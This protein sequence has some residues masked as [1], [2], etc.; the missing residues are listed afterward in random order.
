MGRLFFPSK[1]SDLFLESPWLH[2]V[3]WHVHCSVDRSPVFRQRRGNK[4]MILSWAR[5]ITNKKQTMSATVGNMPMTLTG[6]A[7]KTCCSQLY[8]LYTHNVTGSN[9]NFLFYKWSDDESPYVLLCLASIVENPYTLGQGYHEGHIPSFK[10]LQIEP[11]PRHLTVIM[12]NETKN[13]VEKLSHW[14]SVFNLCLFSWRKQ[15]GHGW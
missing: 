12:K 9:F 3:V 2:P 15:P 11:F 6:I 8:V 1:P 4:R 10:Q 13:D 14:R 5:N 7:S